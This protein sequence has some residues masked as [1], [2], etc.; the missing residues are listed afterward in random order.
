M[1]QKLEK[2]EYICLLL[3]GYFKNKI[4]EKIVKKWNVRH[5][6]EEFVIVIVTCCEKRTKVIKFYTIIQ[7]QKVLQS[8]I[9]DKPVSCYCTHQPQISS[10]AWNIFIIMCPFLSN[11]SHHLDTSSPIQLGCSSSR[12][13]AEINDQVK[14]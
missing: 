2:R 14:M 13:W 12:C 5:F 8:H 1:M 11:C 3:F 4:I 6:D 7:I 9:K 10:S